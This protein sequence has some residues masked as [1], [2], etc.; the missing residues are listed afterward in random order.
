[1]THAPTINCVTDLDRVRFGPLS[2]LYGRQ[3]VFTLTY[4]ALTVFN[5]GAAGA[6]SIEA[7]LV[8]RFFAGVFGSS[9]LTNAG[10]QISDMFGPD[11]L[12]LAMSLFIAAPFIGPTV[13]PIIGGFMSETIGWRWVEGFCAIFTGVQWFM[14]TAFIP[15]TYAP[16]LLKRRAQRLS[17]LNGKVY[18]SKLEIERGTKSPKEIFGTALSRP[19]ALLFWEPIVLLLSSYIAIVYGTLYMFFAAFPIVFQEK[20]GWSEG[21]GGLA[22]TGVAVG[23]LIGVIYAIPE[24]MR[25]MKLVAKAGGKIVPPEQRLM[26]AMV[27]APFIPIGVGGSP[28]LVSSQSAF[29]SFVLNTSA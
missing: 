7:L 18:K 21:L 23:M 20:R 29:S 27:A 24:N 2:E 25:Y 1:M 22:F 5:A 12:G 14:G 4:G 3:W 19:W 11:L 16:V 15:E 13:G 26:P 17:R 28:I 10:G 8:T 6:N 9:P